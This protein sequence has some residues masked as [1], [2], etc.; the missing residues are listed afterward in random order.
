MPSSA[1]L[2]VLTLA[3]PEETSPYHKE[4]RAVDN[5]MV[6]WDGTHVGW[7]PF[8]DKKIEEKYRKFTRSPLF[9]QALY[10][11]LQDHKR[12]AIAHVLLTRYVRR[13]P[14]VDFGEKVPSHWFG[15]RI[16]VRDDGKVFYPAPQQQMRFLRAYWK[17]VLRE[18]KLIP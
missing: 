7:M 2:L 5:S 10:D 14:G 13:V 4:L 3:L 12:F 18:N 11:L 8:V 6:C 1:L 15:L 9:Y 16:A 17:R